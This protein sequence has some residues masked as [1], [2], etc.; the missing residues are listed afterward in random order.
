MLNDSGSC[1]P[2]WKFRAGY[3][4]HAVDSVTDCIAIRQSEYPIL[5]TSGGVNQ[6]DW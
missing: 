2:L 4:F 1:D 6:K 5:D 3:R